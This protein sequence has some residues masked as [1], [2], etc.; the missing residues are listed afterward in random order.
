MVMA[1]RKKYFYYLIA[2]LVIVSVVFYAGFVSKTFRHHVTVP[3]DMLKTG[4]QLYNPANLVKWYI[5]FL[6][7]GTQS[8]DITTKNTIVSGNYS[9]E[10]T[11]QSLISVVLKTH[12]GTNTKEFFFTAAPDTLNAQE[13]MITLSYRNTLFNEWFKR[14][15]LVKNALQSLTNLKDYMEDTKRMYGF[16]ISLTTV[17]DTSFLFISETVPVDEKRVATKKLFEQLF[18]YADKKKA[19]Y[20]GIR[21]F[22]SQKS[23][24]EITLF[25]S[26]GVTNRINIP[27]ADP[28]Q[29]KMMPL[30]KNLLEA[31]YQGPYGE[32]DK[33]FRALESFKK[34]HG[35]VSMAIPFQ[36][37]LSDGYDFA[38][39][40]I[41]QM[42]VYFPIF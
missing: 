8:F 37:F 38:D 17:V 4:E 20:N 36:K 5:P 14:D 15:E 42:K 10:I 41:V 6:Q 9:L 28:F 21:I 25:A 16:E 11:D 31:V 13:S 7:T 29:Y 12:S 19:G 23:G 18:A 35:L 2:V 3:Y 27:P 32:S 34:D 1:F 33:V 26:I 24:D 22:Y 39:D 40:Q 30:G